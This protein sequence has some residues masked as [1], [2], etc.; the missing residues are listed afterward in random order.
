MNAAQLYMNRANPALLSLADG[1]AN[2]WGSL[3]ERC[4]ATLLE[5]RGPRAVAP[6]PPPPPRVEDPAEVHAVRITWP[7]AT[8]LRKYDPAPFPPADGVQ[9]AVTERDGKPYALIKRLLAADPAGAGGPGT[10]GPATGTEYVP[11]GAAEADLVTKLE[12]AV[13]CATH[14]STCELR[15]RAR[16][17][18]TPLQV[19]R[20]ASGVLHHFRHPR[21]LCF[22]SA[23]VCVCVR[24]PRR[25]FSPR[26]VRIE[27]SLQ[28]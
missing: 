14:A 11:L 9:L 27:W 1:S 22:V 25:P 3:L 23:C 20:W 24:D 13:C 19:F 21:S 2:T 7:K 6:P 4:G 12:V 16:G 5:E 26:C 28:A 15:S 8:F 18:A 17:P 10:G